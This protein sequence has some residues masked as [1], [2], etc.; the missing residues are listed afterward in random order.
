[1]NVDS[2]TLVKMKVG[3]SDLFRNE[4]EVRQKFPLYLNMGGVIK[5]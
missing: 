5:Q 2:L 1:M 4:S 3:V